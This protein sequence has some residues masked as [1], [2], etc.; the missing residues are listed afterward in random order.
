M[1]DESPRR[2]KAEEETSESSKAIKQA[3]ALL[4]PRE[5]LNPLSARELVTEGSPPAAQRLQDALE[6]C[7]EPAKTLLTP[8]ELLNPLSAR[9]LVTEGSPPAA[10]RLQDALEECIEPRKAHQ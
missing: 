7:I 3:K 6:E 4:T 5:L 1:S 8:R 2:K 9:E 10:Q